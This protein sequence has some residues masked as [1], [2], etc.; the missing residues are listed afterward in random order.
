MKLCDGR[1]SFVFDLPTKCRTGSNNCFVI[2][3]TILVMRYSSTGHFCN[4]CLCSHTT[5]IIYD[6]CLLYYFFKICCCCCCCCCFCFQAIRTRV[7]PIGEGFGHFRSLVQYEIS[8]SNVSTPNFIGNSI[9]TL[10]T[11]IP[12]IGKGSIQDHEILH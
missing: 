8:S 5:T 2:L 12:D 9:S 6:I 7:S 4:S 10:S 11:D 3:H 1:Y